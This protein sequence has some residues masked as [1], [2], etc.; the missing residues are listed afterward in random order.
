M[1]TESK[2]K[3]PLLYSFRRCP[4]AM[5]ARMALYQAGLQCEI[6]EVELKAKPAAMLA[7]SPKGSVPVLQLPSGEVLDESLDIMRWALTQHD[8][9]A[10]LPAATRLS[11]TLI[12]ENDGGFKAALDR[13]KYPQRFPDSHSGEARAEGLVFIS[14]LNTQLNGHAYL[15]GPQVSFVD[16]ALFPFVRQFANT[17]LPWFAAQALPAVQAWLDSL[18]NSALFKTIM[19]KN[20]RHLL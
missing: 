19:E 14:Q 1:T 12:E 4:Y 8:P 16:I 3:Y 13:Y 7:L 15:L 6:V 11:E 17:D 20:R 10:W 5:R 9:T 2:A 18:V